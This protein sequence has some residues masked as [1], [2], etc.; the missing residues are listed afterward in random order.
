MPCPSPLLA[1]SVTRPLGLQ[2]E[3]PVGI[4]QGPTGRYR[5]G[6]WAG[7]RGLERA[8]QAVQGGHKCHRPGDTVPTDCGAADAALCCED[9]QLWVE[10]QQQAGRGEGTGHQHHPVRWTRAPVVTRPQG[11]AAARGTRKE[12]G[13]PRP[14]PRGPGPGARTKLPFSARMDAVLTRSP[15]IGHLRVG[16]A[17][18]ASLSPVLTLFSVLQPSSAKTQTHA[19]RHSHT[20]LQ[21]EAHPETHTQTHIDMQ[22]KDIHTETPI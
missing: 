17:V 10:E 4:I 16:D 19:H 15:S 2:C 22:T 9:G 12:P 14:H 8:T 11:G 6:T 1:P 3:S 18:S 5:L 13:P 21:K 7:V 20:L